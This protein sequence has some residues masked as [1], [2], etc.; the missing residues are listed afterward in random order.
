MPYLRKVHEEALEFFSNTYY[1]FLNQI[2]RIYTLESL[3]EVE[4]MLARHKSIHF[5]V[6]KHLYQANREL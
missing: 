1:D 5:E 6:I 4:A 3:E 2:F